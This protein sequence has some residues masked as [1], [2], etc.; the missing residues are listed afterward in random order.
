MSKK[1]ISAPANSLLSEGYLVCDIKEKVVYMKCLVI[2]DIEQVDKKL[3]LLETVLEYIVDLLTIENIFK[4]DNATVTCNEV[5]IP[6]K[7]I[8]KLGG[9][10]HDN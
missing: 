8:I 3:E 5:S 7:H 9:K 6:L 4:D 10:K 1:I 2:D